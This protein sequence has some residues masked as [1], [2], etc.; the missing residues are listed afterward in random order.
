MRRFMIS[1]LKV[2]DE[3]EGN[4]LYNYGYY[5]GRIEIEKGKKFVYVE[6]MKNLPRLEKVTDSTGKVIRIR[7]AK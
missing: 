4:I 6:K 3:T 1:N 5:A 2:D 7:V